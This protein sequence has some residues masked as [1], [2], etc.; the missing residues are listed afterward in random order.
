MAVLLVDNDDDDVDCAEDSRR[1]GNKSSSP[2]GQTEQP[3]VLMV[4]ADVVGAV[5]VGDVVVGAVVVGVVVVGVVVVLTKEPT[6][7]PLLMVS[8][9]PSP[10]VLLFPTG[11]SVLPQPGIVDKSTG[12]SPSQP[13]ASW[14]QTCIALHVGSVSWYEL[15][16]TCRSNPQVMLK[17]LLTP[18]G[19][20]SV[21]C[22]YSASD[23]LARKASDAATVLLLLLVL[24]QSA[25]DVASVPASTG[26]PQNEPTD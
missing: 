15:T 7:S 16:R 23:L 20:T 5:V 26:Q 11:F 18:G 24:E 2:P 14:N 21:G 19:K 8:F 25:Q 3:L 13:H 4:V 9:L 1:F 17:L 22:T 10:L 12:G 6:P